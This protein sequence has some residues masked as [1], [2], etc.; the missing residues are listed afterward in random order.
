MLSDEIRSRQLPPLRSV[1]EMKEIMQREVYG[2]L[3]DVPFTYEISEPAVIDD[4][5]DCGNVAFS[6]VNMT[7]H[8]GDKSHTFRIDRLMHTDGKK[9][10][11]IIVNNFHL[12]E[13]SHYF[14]RE[15]MSE[16][17]VVLSFFIYKTFHW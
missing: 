10:P 15:E 13:A 5:Y 11:L 1:E 8:F 6:F 7:L 16:Y 2:Y 17:D 14:P 4:R 9:R 3:P 12:M